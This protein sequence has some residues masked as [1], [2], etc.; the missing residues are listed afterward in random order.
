MHT[1]NSHFV[2]SVMTKKDYL[3]A[4]M[5]KSVR[6]GY[7]IHTS[8]ELAAMLCEQNTA[9]FRKFLSDCA[10]KKIIKRVANGIYESESTPVCRSLAIYKVASKI[11][12]H[13][14]SYIS[15]ESA[16]LMSH[17]VSKSDLTGVAELTLMT[18]GRSGVF[19]TEYGSIEFI[20]TRKS[21]E[22]LLSGMRY[23]EKLSMY[24]ATRVLAIADLRDCNRAR[25]LLDHLR[26]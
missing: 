7:G 26:Y 19:N 13:H 10:R 15:L 18:T 22:R 1:E 16:L 8:S 12:S 5:S 23:D 14:L 9:A 4:A 2:D 11:R 24:R 25:N 17:D 21:T 6:S 3:V 20:H